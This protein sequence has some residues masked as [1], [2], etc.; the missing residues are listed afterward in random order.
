MNHEYFMFRVCLR[1]SERT[2]TFKANKSIKFKMD[3]N[4]GGNLLN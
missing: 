1:S 4:N 2:L 3:L